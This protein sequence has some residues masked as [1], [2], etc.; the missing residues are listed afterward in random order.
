[1]FY[2]GQS[3]DCASLGSVD[4][5]GVDGGG[6]VGN[7]TKLGDLC[8]EGGRAR[9]EVSNSKWGYAKAL[10]LLTQTERYI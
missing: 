10:I 5:V 4:F 1:L 3:N 9:T 6:I 7:A 8:S 2:L